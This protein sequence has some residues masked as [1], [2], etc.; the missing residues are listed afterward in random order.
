MATTHPTINTTT[1]P[2]YN[3]LLT[4]K[5]KSIFYD[6]NDAYV[7]GKREF[8]RADILKRLYKDNDPIQEALN[9]IDLK[10]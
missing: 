8:R 5:L 2:K 6:L 9:S 4:R 10:L 3:F 7:F 1:I